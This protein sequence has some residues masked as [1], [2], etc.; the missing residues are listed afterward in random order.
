MIQTQVLVI[1]AGPGGYVAA[2]KLAKLG[3][4]VLLV[5]KHKL[6]G[7]CLNYGCIP[8]KALIALANNVHK[9]K[10][11][12][13]MGVEIQGLSVNLEK[14]QAWKNNMVGNLGRGIQGLL[15][16]NSV[17]FLAGEAVL[18]GP[19]SAKVKA[20]GGD[21]EIVFEHAILA[22]GSKPMEIPGFAVDGQWVLGSKEA[23]DLIRLPESLLV[24]GGGVIGLEIGTLYAKLGAQ[25]T[26]VEFMSQLLP[27]LEPDLAAYVLRSLGKLGV[28]IYL[29]AQALGYSVE[30]G[31]A[32][33]KLKISE[34]EAQMSAEKIFLCVGRRPNSQN[35]GLEAAGIEVDNKGFIQVNE[36]GET[37]ASGIYA[38]GDVT[39]GPLLA[40]RSSS[41]GIAVAQA[42]ALP[43][44]PH[45][46]IPPSF[47]PWAVFTD[48][49][50]ACVGLSE[51]EAKEKG[52]PV[53]IGK[54]PFAASGRA[55]AAGEPEGFVKVVA[56]KAT[57]K[58]LG[59]SMVGP[60]ASDLI[61]EACLAVR[62]GATI[63]DIASTV[64]PHPTLP[65]AFVEACEAAVGQA[66]HIL[67][68]RPQI[69]T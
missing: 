1:G 56:D 57:Q 10:K 36:H 35:L 16:G 13:E 22:T 39:P 63:E 61:S 64:H 21:E 34:G 37:T 65:E 46:P 66:I 60:E 32:V 62:L 42:I 19:R 14:F 53:L 8:S 24:I 49:Q 55:M 12:K 43:P 44:S 5:D 52:R 58:V 69:A 28:K 54:F 41:E 29:G 6:G 67:P 4:K 51:K 2:I 27:G 11:A 26:V 15:K 3:K 30:G 31:R 9:I 7:E 48:P 38:I 25:V 18:T 23:L 47:I 33:V 50:I 59:V 45:P 20:A 17:N 40:H 68:P